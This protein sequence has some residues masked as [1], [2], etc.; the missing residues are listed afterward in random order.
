MLKKFR[1]KFWFS[2]ENNQ[3]QF[4]DDKDIGFRLYYAKDLVGNLSFVDGYWKFEYSDEFKIQDKISP[5]INFP[6]KEKI[7]QSSTLWPFFASRVPSNTQLMLSGETQS[8]DLTS[9]LK[10]YG[11]RSITNPFELQATF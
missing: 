4:V 3:F 8:N 6:Q 10:K 5:L 2:G 1:N 9:L 11:K 7:Y